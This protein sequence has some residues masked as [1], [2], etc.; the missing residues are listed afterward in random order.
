MTRHTRITVGIMVGALAAG[1]IAVAGPAVAEDKRGGTGRGQ[2][3]AV[4]P[5]RTL[6]TK[7]DVARTLAAA[8]FGT[9]EVRYGVDTYQLVYRTVDPAGRPT[10]ASGLVALPRGGARELRVVSYTHGTEINRTDAPSMWRDG[11]AVAPALTY[12]SAGFAA[13]APDY[14]GMGVGPG[15]HPYLDVPSE[16]TAAVDLLRA[17]REFTSGTG[18]TLERK[19]LVTG[20]SQGGTAATGLARA[21]AAGADGWFRL[22]ALS[23]IAGPYDGRRQVLPV[24]AGMRPPYNT[25]Y[26]AYL[27]VSYNR[28]HHIYDQPSDVFKKEGVEEVFDGVHTGE[29]LAETLGG[30]LDEL[31]TPRGKAL[32]DNPTGP[33]AAALAVHDSTCTGWTPR[34]PVRLVV[35]SGDE[36]IVVGNATTCRASF[37]ASGVDAPVVDAGDLVYDGSKHLGANIV[38]TANTLKWFKTL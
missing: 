8:E 30:S 18:R 20:F 5:L 15:P 33:F 10:I 19:V 26:T 7:D 29:E 24:L 6:P 16:T 21:L 36:Q 17:A 34:A 2:V 37:A 13:V 31:L 12:A 22:G 28:L 35:S 14:L 4:Q 23:P 25:G 27:L 32:I 3:V 11:W 38:G 1:A 9:G